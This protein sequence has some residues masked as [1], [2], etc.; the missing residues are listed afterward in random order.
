V[1]LRDAIAARY[2][3]VTFDVVGVSEG[4]LVA[5]AAVEPGAWND[6]R[7]I[8]QSVRNL[9]TIATPHLGV[10]PDTGPSLLSDL[11]SSEMRAGAQFLADLNARPDS[12]P[13]RYT[14]IAGDGW[15]GASD[16][17]VGVDS[18]LGRGV[19]TSARAVTLTL[20][21]APSLGADAMPCNAQVYQTIAAV[22]P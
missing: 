5:R 10:L 15:R 16:G 11:A 21:H 20:V 1:W 18:A 3:G 22:A 17:L 4:G 13:V 7:T 9:I 2:P 14:T 6:G 8:A 12:G 19:L